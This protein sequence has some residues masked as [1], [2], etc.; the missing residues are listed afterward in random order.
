MDVD[1]F[2]AN[3][4]NYCTPLCTA[5]SDCTP[6]GNPANGCNP[7]SK[8]CEKKDNARLPYGAA[9]T[10]DLDCESGLCLSP[11]G[12]SYPGGYC[13]GLC[14]A[15][16]G[17][18]GGDG[19]CIHAASWGDNTGICYDGCSADADCRVGTAYTCQTLTSDVPAGNAQ[20]CYCR[21]TGIACSVGTQ[22]CSGTCAPDNISGLSKC[23]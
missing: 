3:D 12:A 16:L 14:N 6:T 8:L 13:S 18:C 17:G 19:R 20:V 9:C 5:D 22:C 10:K 1:S 2:P 4:N 11:S 21:G 7:F 23:N 15:S